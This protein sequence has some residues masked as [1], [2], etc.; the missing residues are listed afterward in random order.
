M[1]PPR[2]LSD[3]SQT[4]A[5]EQRRFF[6]RQRRTLSVAKGQAIIT[7]GTT[8]T[9]VYFIAEGELEVRLYAQSGRE[10]LLRIA[11]PGDLLGELAAIDEGPRSATVTARTRSKVWQL[12][13]ADFRRILESSPKASQWILARHAAIIRGLTDRLYELM[14]FSVNTRICAELVRLIDESAVETN[15]Y[16]ITRMPTHREFASKV[17]TTREAVTR[18]FSDLARQKLISKMRGREMTILDVTGLKALL[19]AMMDREVKAGKKR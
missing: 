19:K 11:G 12:S 8:A 16:R 2:Q 6:E 1:P 3:F 7:H 5:P 9:E 13:A 10:V 4:L 17:G 14:V 18:Q 15:R